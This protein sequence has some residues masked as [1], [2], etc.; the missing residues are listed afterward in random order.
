MDLESHESQKTGRTQDNKR[1]EHS[2]SAEKSSAK[3][4]SVKAESVKDESS[5]DESDLEEIN[6][7]QH[8]DNKGIESRLIKL[9]NTFV[10][11]Q[12]KIKEEVKSD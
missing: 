5:E 10:K 2:S 8:I 12:K 7:T 6:P 3:A 4:V 9:N 1:S 11:F